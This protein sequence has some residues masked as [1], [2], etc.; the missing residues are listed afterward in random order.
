M[1]KNAIIQQKLEKERF[2]S[3]KYIPREKLG[4]FKQVLSSDMIKVI[5]GP[6]RA[7]KSVFAILLLKNEDFAYVDFDDEALL[8][9]DNYD[10]IL[11]A[12]LE[13]YPKSKYFLFDEIQNL[14]KWEVFVSKLH[15]RGYNLVLT[16]S[17]ARLLSSELSTALTGRYAAVEILPFSFGEF[18]LARNYQPAQAEASPEVKATLLGFL[19]EYLY[20]GG[21]P[22]VTVKNLEV[23]P[24]LQTLFDA[25]LLKDVVKRFRVR[26]TQQIYDLA[27]YLMAHFAAEFSYTK[28]RNA[29]GLRSTATVEKYAGYLEEAYLLYSLSRFSHKFKEQLKAPK[30]AY[31]VDTGFLTAKAFQ[32]SPNSGRLM[33]NVVFIELIRRG[34]VPNGGIFYYK[35]RNNKEVDF[36]LRA[37]TK[38]EWLIQVC[39]DI[40]SEGTRKREQDALIEAGE[41][42]DC[43]RLTILSWDT[44]AREQVKGKEIE[45]VPLWKWLL[46]GA[47]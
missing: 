8:K 12:L 41:E 2:L 27:Q 35:T 10:A 42:L 3:K 1:L 11:T 5:T 18:L 37:G 19:E 44:E 17:N 4:A 20:Q 7:G 28:L 30:K 23:K 45:I 39:M 16:G 24:Y 32:V 21:Y 29:L 38:V 15:R 9:P 46:Q 43:N 6:R 40:D 34:Y 25:L 47:S 22:E 14:D 13:V 33:E 31:F 36:I 26:Y